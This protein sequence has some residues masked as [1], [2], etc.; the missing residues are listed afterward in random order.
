MPNVRQS[1]STVLLRGEISRKSS[2][3]S[4]RTTHFASGL[5][6]R[7]GR[8]LA[9][10]LV[11]IRFRRSRLERRMESLQMNNWLT[12]AIRKPTTSH[13]INGYRIISCI[14]ASSHAVRKTIHQLLCKASKLG[15]S[16][17]AQNC[18]LPSKLAAYCVVSVRG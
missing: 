7:C 18:G 2:P 5:N 10:Q 17:D 11:E 13:S 9:K 12:K 6:R 14:T 1:T 8:N 3:Q 4:L 15:V 16:G